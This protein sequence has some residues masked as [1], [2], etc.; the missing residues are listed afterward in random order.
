MLDAPGALVLPLISCLSLSHMLVMNQG[1][2]TSICLSLTCLVFAIVLAI[3]PTPETSSSPQ[4]EPVGH[5]H[6]TWN[7]THNIQYGKVTQLGR[8]GAVETVWQN[9]IIN[10]TLECTKCRMTRLI[11]CLRGT[12]HYRCYR[13]CFN[14][15]GTDWD[16]AIR[17]TMRGSR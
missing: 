12:C 4:P 16:E 9:V 15:N 7:H 11:G 1:K 14:G 2:R 3:D 6:G 10:E 17:F 5:S 8:N 13:R